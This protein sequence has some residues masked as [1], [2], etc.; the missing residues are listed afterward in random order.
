[1]TR[2]S[3]SPAGAG[4]GRGRALLALA[5]G[6]ALAL[7]TGE[8]LARVYG[9]LS[10]DAALRAASLQGDSIG[11]YDSLLGYR[12]RPGARARFAGPEFD[13][14]VAINAQGLRMDREVAYER[15]PGRRRILLAGDSFTFG[16]GVDAAQRFGER[17]EFLLPGVE[18]INMG[19]WGTGTDQQLLLYLR[20]GVRYTPDVVV[21]AYMTEN[22]QRNSSGAR[23]QADGRLVPKPRYV[24][25]GGTL[26]LTNVPVP[27]EGAIS[28]DEERERW[29]RRWRRWS[30]PIPIPFRA[31]L[32]THSALY[33]L[34]QRRLA[35][36]LWALAGERTVQYAEYDEAREEWHL[37]AALLTR[38]AAEVRGRGAQF[39]LVLVPANLGIDGRP[40]EML[41][42]LAAAQAIDVVDLLPTLRA[43]TGAG[44]SP[45]YY[46][47]DGHWTPAAHRLVGDVLADHLR[48]RTAGS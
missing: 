6:T 39:L 31:F 45:L 47:A 14:S 7:A 23:A 48:G 43:A 1:V 37:T 38:F 17:L 40:H 29:E 32:R 15:T 36:A 34:A 27:V 30:L 9:A 8:G 41:R 21:L 42:A 13:T 24:L 4:T 10:N 25:E 28:G 3:R 5:L 11:E 22:I 16:H 18:V 2:A 12:L 35:G 33:Q 46:P 26:V 20:E 19:V 44:N